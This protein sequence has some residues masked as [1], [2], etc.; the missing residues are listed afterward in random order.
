[1]RLKKVDCE[2]P[3]YIHKFIIFSYWDLK[4]WN[5]NVNSTNLKTNKASRTKIRFSILTIKF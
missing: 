1:M 2:L 5:S 3:G 4:F